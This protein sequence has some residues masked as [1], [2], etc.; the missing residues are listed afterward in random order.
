M[1]EDPMA[2]NTPRPLVYTLTNEQKI[3]GTLERI[4]KLLEAHSTPFVGAAP[5]GSIG[6]AKPGELIYVKKPRR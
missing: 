6:D 5:T 2:M 3:L 1:S 4:E